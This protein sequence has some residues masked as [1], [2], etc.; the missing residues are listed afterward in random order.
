MHTCLHYQHLSN[1]V[2]CHE[3]GMFKADLCRAAY[4]YL[5]GGYYFDVD[6][7]VV[8]PFVAPNNATFVTVKGEGFPRDG[9]FQAF[10]AAEKGNGIVHRSLQIMEEA[11]Y[12]DRPQGKYLGPTALME[13]WLEVT[14]VNHPLNVDLSVEQNLKYGV[15]LLT[16]VSMISD[17]ISKYKSLSNAIAKKGG[18]GLMQRVPKGHGDDCQFS[19][20]ACNAVV[21]D[22]SSN[23]TLYFYS[24]VLGTKWCGKRTHEHGECPQ[25]V[26][27]GEVEV[28]LSRCSNPYLAGS[29]NITMR[30]FGGTYPVESLPKAY[31]CTYNIYDEPYLWE[32][33]LKSRL[34]SRI[35]ENSLT[36]CEFGGLDVGTAAGDWVIAVG[37][38][39]RKSN[40]AAYEAR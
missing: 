22:E 10:A 1:S 4:L 14:N 12:G 36:D 17:S 32:R 25:R 40:F 15:Y 20:G 11:L 39:A 30:G 16:E 24:R 18:V 13:A 37:S 3:K 6:L 33:R 38:F 8:R 9:F 29:R 35:I 2:Q 31:T 7:L 23:E 27:R 21:I 26:Q 19:S 5:Y 28:T 34:F